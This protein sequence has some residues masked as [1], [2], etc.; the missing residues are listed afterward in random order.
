M[1]GGI[2][3]TLTVVIIAIASLQPKTNYRTLQKIF[4]SLLVIAVVYTLLNIA[5]IEN[6]P[7]CNLRIFASL[8]SCQSLKEDA[9]YRLIG[10]MLFVFGVPYVV[11]MVWSAIMRKRQIGIKQRKT[12]NAPKPSTSYI[13]LVDKKDRGLLPEKTPALDNATNENIIKNLCEDLFEISDEACVYFT[14]EGFGFMIAPHLATSFYAYGIACIFNDAE[15]S[16]SRRR[17]DLF[18][19]KLLSTAAS[20]LQMPAHTIETMAGLRPGD[21]RLTADGLASYVKAND[22]SNKLSKHTEFSIILT[23]KIQRYVNEQLASL[24]TRASRSNS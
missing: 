5:S 4:T 7:E 24:A 15:E 19:P 20:I 13:P 10:E 1:M 16:L 14:N 2:T 6:P 22:A 11:L 12:L 3:L 17:L 23:H 8:G 21:V 9:T 18:K